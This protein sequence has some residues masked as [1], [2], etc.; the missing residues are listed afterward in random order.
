MRPQR[1]DAE[2]AELSAEKTKKKI[3]GSGALH[4]TSGMSPRRVYF[5]RVEMRSLRLFGE[6]TLPFGQVFA[7]SGS[8][9]YGA[10]LTQRNPM[11]WAAP[12]SGTVELAQRPVGSSLSAAKKDWPRTMYHGSSRVGGARFSSLNTLPNSVKAPS[13][14]GLT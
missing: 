9:H 7:R 3:G 10:S 14:G 11:F 5:S 1:R 12:R 4:A 8:A 6:V 2:S 13:P